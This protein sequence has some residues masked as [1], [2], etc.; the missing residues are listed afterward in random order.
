MAGKRM[1]KAQFIN[2][3]AEKTGMNKKQAM[4]TLDT[5]NAMAVEQLGTNG[6]LVIPGLVKLNVATKPAT[7]EHS[8]INPF[9]KQPMMFKAKPARKVIRAHP[10]KALKDAI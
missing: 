10:V 9:T 2:A 7:A 4:A 5:L 3:L 6:E 1:S 8:G